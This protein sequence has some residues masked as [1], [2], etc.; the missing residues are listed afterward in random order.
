MQAASTVL[1]MCFNVQIASIP[2]SSILHM[3]Q[4]GSL[5]YMCDME[6]IWSKKNPFFPTC[7][8]PIESAL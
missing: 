5:I 3:R 1:C 6:N 7:S 2:S 4:R 8:Y